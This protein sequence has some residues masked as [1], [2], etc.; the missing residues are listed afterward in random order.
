MQVILSVQSIHPPLTGIGRYAYELASRLST[1]SEISDLRFVNGARQVPHPDDQ[2]NRPSMLRQLGRWAPFKSHARR[3]YHAACNYYAEYQFRKLAPHYVY[4]EPNYILGEYSGPSIATIHDLSH[5][6]YPEFHPSDRIDFLNRELPKTLDKAQHLITVSE[7][8][9]Q[10]MISLLGIP[11]HRVTAIHNGVD[12]RFCPMTEEQT[13]PVRQKYGLA[14]A[15]YLLVVATLEPRKNLSRLLDAYMMLSSRIRQRHP[16]VLVGAKGWQDSELNQRLHALLANG[17]VRKLGY[18]DDIDLPALYA[19]AHAF[20]FPSLY[21][22]FGLPVLE[23]IASGI[24]TLTSHCSSLPEVVGNSGVT[25]NPLDVDALREGLVELLE[26]TSW[27]EFASQ[28][29]PLHAKQFSW[30]QC[31]QRTVDVY[32][33]VARL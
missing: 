15:R 25:I 21:E 7:F 20:A 23:A 22:G 33:H 30:E 3:A 12:S 16:L 17:M 10:E 19:G 13:L 14:D 24:P 4:H 5:I 26:N 6:H 8:V 18:V 11:P 29:G 9:R 2:L 32:G 28:A 31:V 1:A 27:R